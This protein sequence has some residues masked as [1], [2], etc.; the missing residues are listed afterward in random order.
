[1]M[2]CNNFKKIRMKLQLLLTT[3]LSS[4]FSQLCVL[5]PFRLFPSHLN[6]HTLKYIVC[7]NLIVLPC[8]SLNLSVSFHINLSCSF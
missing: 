6:V 3:L 7:G 4:L 1:M 5:F 2:F 8:P